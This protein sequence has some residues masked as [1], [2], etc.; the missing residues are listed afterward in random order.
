MRNIGTELE[1]LAHESPDLKWLYYQ[2]DIYTLS[3][4]SI[5]ATKA[6]NL[7]LSLGVKKG[8]KVAL[9]LSNS[10]E[11]IFAWFGLA[12]IGA[13]MVPINTS[14]KG[15]M[16]SYIINHSDAV[17]AIVED[18][19]FM[20]YQSIYPTLEKVQ[21]TI[22]LSDHHST[23]E[24]KP[25]FHLFERALNAQ[26]TF[27]RNRDTV[28]LENLMCIL[29]T[30]GTTGVPKGVMLSQNAYMEAGNISANKIFQFRPNDIIYT[31]LPFFHVNAQMGT[32]MPALLSKIP[33]AIGKKFSASQFWSEMKKYNV[34]IFKFIGAMITILY[35]TSKDVKYDN[36]VR[37]GLGAPVP[38]DLWEPFQER[39]GLQL[40][41]GYGT[42]ETSTACIANTPSNFRI[43]SCGKPLT[44]YEASIRDDNNHPLS[45]NQPGELCLKP[46]K[47]HVFMEGYYKME[48]KTKEAFR[49]GWFHTGDRVYR[50]EDGFYFFMDRTK[51][52]IRRKGENISS[53]MVEKIINNHPRV[54]ESAAIGVPNELSEEEVKVFVIPKPGEAIS[55]QDVYNYC[56]KHMSEFMLP[57]YIEFIQELPKT[58][59]EK[60]Q[61]FKL[62]EMT[63]DQAWD[64]ENRVHLK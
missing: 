37:L 14:T 55:A 34:T 28:S 3:E 36:P 15:E 48:Q 25:N 33:M 17:L 35:K 27:F 8:D 40:L 56:K 39:F 1:Q 16:L 57:R 41:E 58:P 22:V 5:K 31:C 60:I 62:K 42:T 30:S 13:V 10:P 47:N 20:E 23:V 59:T 52:V 64:A 61:K 7:F 38:K 45:A 24:N 29:Y 46:L 26:S 43:G 12:K 4:I 32:T 44:S 19:F 11:Y 2:D 21:N 18:Q 6:A 9:L 53:Y 50:D 51:D 49:D 63:N 54:Y